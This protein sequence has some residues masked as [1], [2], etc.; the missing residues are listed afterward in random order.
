[1]TNIIKALCP[2]ILF[3]VLRRLRHRRVSS[4][5]AGNYPSWDQAK[6]DSSGYDAANILETIKNSALKVKRGE[7]TF[8]RDSVCFYHVEYRYP[9]L[10]G[11]LYAALSSGSRL[12]VLDFGGSLASFYSQHAAILSS[13]QNLRWGVVE[14]AHF[15]V[16]GQENLNTRVLKFYNTPAEFALEGTPD[17]IFLSSVLQYMEKPYQLLE[18][19][20]QLDAEFFLFD[21]TSFNDG[22]DRLS[23]QTVPPSIYPASYPAWFLSWSKFLDTMSSAGYE[24]I[25]EFPGTDPTEIGYYKGLLFKRRS[26][27]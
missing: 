12:S 20:L 13:V 8:E 9:A 4:S 16:C 14:Q 1:M 19:L 17:V 11:L 2:P 3:Q 15:V 23:V 7:A 25:M 27:H 24:I 5:F 18:E 22:D 6:L 10:S 21:R 26:T